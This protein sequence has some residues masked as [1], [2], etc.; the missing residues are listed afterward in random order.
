MRHQASLRRDGAVRSGGAPRRRR[1]ALGRARTGNRRLRT[2]RQ[3]RRPLRAPPLTRPRREA[4]APGSGVPGGRP[5][6]PRCVSLQPAHERFRLG[7]PAKSDEYLHR[8]RDRAL[9]PCQVELCGV[10]QKRPGELRLPEGQLEKPKRPATDSPKKRKWT[11]SPWATPWRTSSRACSVSPR[12]AAS[13]ARRTH[14]TPSLRRSPPSKASSDAW[15][16]SRSVR[17]VPAANST[18]ARST[19]SGRVR[20]PCSSSPRAPP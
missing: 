5:Q 11:A 4:R 9:R 2:P 19:R 15:S 14:A 8:V 16:R 3:T 6:V 10:C 1:A 7:E 18:S 13:S 12:S 20:A 17:S